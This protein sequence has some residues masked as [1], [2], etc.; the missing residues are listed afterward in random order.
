MIQQTQV[1]SFSF[2]DVYAQHSPAVRNYLASRNGHCSL[3]DQDDLGQEVFMRFW[4]QKKSFKGEIAVKAYL[5]G[6]AKN[7]LKEHYRQIQRET[8][9]FFSCLSI[10]RV[11]QYFRAQFPF[12]VIFCNSPSA[13]SHPNILL[14][15][16]L[17]TNDCLEECRCRWNNFDT[18][19]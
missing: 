5:F 6:I 1:N 2:D 13:E 10:S 3:N 18:H 9:C 14:Y 19:T 15:I 4:Q 12:Y 16:K 17:C 8:P 11:S 7:V